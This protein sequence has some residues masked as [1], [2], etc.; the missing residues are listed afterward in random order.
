MVPRAHTVTWIGKLGQS[1]AVVWPKPYIDAHS[2][3][4]VERDDVSI[5]EALR[6]TGIKLPKPK[7]SRP[8]MFNCDGCGRFISDAQRFEHNCL[9][10]GADNRP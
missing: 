4:L 9:N 10:C 3:R 6:G 2:R 5:K 1:G 8:M 7:K